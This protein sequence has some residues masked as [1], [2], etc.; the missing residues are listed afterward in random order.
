MTDKSAEKS[1]E[2]LRADLAAKRA[3]L[4]DTVE[5]LAHRV[6]VPAQVKAKKDDTLAK[7]QDAKVE[8]TRRVHE[9]TEKVKAAIADKTPVVQHK[10]DQAVS[11]SKAVYTEKAPPAV[12]EKVGQAVDRGRAVYAEKA[13]VV[14]QHVNKVVADARPVVQEKVAQGQALLAEKAPPVERT[15]REKPGLV[16]G[17]AVALVVLLIATSRK[18]KNT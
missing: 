15:L 1:P 4:G 14:Q 12:Q 8:A 16:A 10:V 18:K 11:R 6:D 3:E 17:I 9:G 13:P 5:E 7:L 2:E